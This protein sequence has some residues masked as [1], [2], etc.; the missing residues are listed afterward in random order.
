[1]ISGADTT[2][3][4]QRAG[5]G[6]LRAGSPS[7]LLLLLSSSSASASTFAV[8]SCDRLGVQ[9]LLMRAVVGRS[10]G[11]ARWMRLTTWFDGGRAGRDYR[12][13]SIGEAADAW[14]SAGDAR[15]VRCFAL[16]WSPFPGASKKPGA[17]ERRRSLRSRPLIAA[18]GPSSSLL[19]SRTSYSLKVKHIEKEHERDHEPDLG[20]ICEQRQTNWKGC[21]RRRGGECG[22]KRG[23]R[24]RC[25][26]RSLRRRQGE[27]WRCRRRCH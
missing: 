3:V 27:M 13:G 6:Y 17:A 5:R 19:R 11:W 4:L 18:P 21:W 10:R 7:V 24:S 12:Y 8:A 23:R 22:W 15:G 1:M 20:L 26:C 16:H 9:K 14:L 25:R 2:R